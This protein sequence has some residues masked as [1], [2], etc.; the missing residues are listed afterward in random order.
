M[1]KSNCESE[2]V[3]VTQVL[4]P[5]SDFSKVPPEVLK[6]ACERGSLTHDFCELYAL[7]SLIEPVPEICKGYFESFKNWFDQN[8]CEVI[9]TEERLYHETLYF[10]GQYD[11]LCRFKSDPDSIVLVDYKTPQMAS[12]SWQM[13]SGAY[14]ILLDEVRQIKV[15]RRLTVQLKKDGSHA[16][17]IEYTNH[18]RDSLLFLNALEIYRF[19]NH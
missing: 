4:S 17:I 1:K 10:T 7:D 6:V 2:Y 3:R 12:K 13:Q 14:L 16:A 18:M 11:L 15:D 19:F 9:N 5:Y 8:I